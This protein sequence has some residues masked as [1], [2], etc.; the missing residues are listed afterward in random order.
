MSGYVIGPPYMTRSGYPGMYPVPK[1]RQAPRVP[2]YFPRMKVRG[3]RRRRKWEWQTRTF[4]SALADA[5]T[6]LDRTE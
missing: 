5:R 2:V 6:G 3:H 4:R 1:P